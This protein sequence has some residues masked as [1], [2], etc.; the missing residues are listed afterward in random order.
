MARGRTETHKR[1]GI[2]NAIEKISNANY[3]NIPSTSKTDSV[4]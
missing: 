1:S 4:F 2:Y 3:S